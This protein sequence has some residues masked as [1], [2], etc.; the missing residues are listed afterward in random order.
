MMPRLVTKLPM[1][2]SCLS[3]TTRKLYHD[4]VAVRS[5]AT[6]A[7]ELLRKSEIPAVG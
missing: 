1:K 6:T 2:S 7:L 5:F 3:I 4:A